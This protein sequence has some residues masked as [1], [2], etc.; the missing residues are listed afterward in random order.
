MEGH[1]TIVSVVEGPKWNQGGYHRV[2]MRDGTDEIVQVTFKL[3]K[4]IS[5]KTQQRTRI[6]LTVSSLRLARTIC[7]MHNESLE[8]TLSRQPFPL[9]AS[10]S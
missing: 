1:R 6:L 4:Q 5:C 8:E 2:L 10:T 9:Y 3:G 7:R